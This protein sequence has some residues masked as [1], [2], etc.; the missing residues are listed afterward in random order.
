MHDLTINVD[1]VYSHHD[2]KLKDYSCASADGSGA[3]YL[4]NLDD[5]LIEHIQKATIAVGCVAWL[6]SEPIL[7]ALSKLEAVSIIVQK[8]DFLRP[9]ITKESKRAWAKKIRRLYQNLPSSGRDDWSELPM[10][11]YPRVDWTELVK[12][13]DHTPADLTPVDNL[14]G[15]P[16]LIGFGLISN[17]ST[18]GDPS[19]EA[20]RC[21]GNH[22]STNAPAFAR[23]HNKF[24]VFCNRVQHEGDMYVQPYA[25]WFGSFNFTKNAGRSLE[26][27][28][29]TTDP[30]YVHAFFQEWEQTV[31]ISEPLDWK[32]PWSA[33]E[34]R[35]GT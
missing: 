8:E 1:S 26:S 2:G 34:W 21:V 29:Y 30:N 17:L 24:L 23:E 10:P 25:A 19:M 33:P 35:I 13:S 6:T 18:L 12:N 15:D 11:N 5:R 22:N 14:D 31:A 32:T 16:K 7:I 28:T 3:L 9:D 20:V 4:R 27:A